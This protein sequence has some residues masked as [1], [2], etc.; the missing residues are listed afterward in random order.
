[1]FVSLLLLVIMTP[2]TDHAQVPQKINYQG[3]L[4]D[5]LGIPNRWNGI[6]DFCY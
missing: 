6:N 5:L 1:M 4:M 3:V 2:L